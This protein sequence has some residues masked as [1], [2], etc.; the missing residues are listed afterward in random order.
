MRTHKRVRATS[1]SGMVVT[2]VALREDALRALLVISAERRTVMTELVRNAI[3]Q[4]LARQ[5]RAKARKRGGRK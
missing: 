5:S 4:W 3:D 1:R 2:T